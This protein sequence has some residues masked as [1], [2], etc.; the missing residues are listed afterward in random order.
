MK[1]EV[2]EIGAC[3]RRLQIVEEP[4]VVQE[5]WQR[6]FSRVQR[7]ARFPASARARCR[8]A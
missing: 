5:A 8:S 4:A 7:Q 3:K 2:E 1:V 6:A